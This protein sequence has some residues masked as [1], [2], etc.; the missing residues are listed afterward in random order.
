M[1]E[2]WDM[3][4]LVTEEF[5]VAEWPFCDCLLMAI[6]IKLGKFCILQIKPSAIFKDCNIHLIYLIGYLIGEVGS[7]RNAPLELR[8]GHRHRI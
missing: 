3:G 2:P 7:S 4:C 1:K 6:K 8:F 5:R